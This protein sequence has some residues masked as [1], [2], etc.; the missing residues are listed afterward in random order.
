MFE[1]FLP[2]RLCLWMSLLQI[3]IVS[4]GI[5]CRTKKV[6]VGWGRMDEQSSVGCGRMTERVREGRL[7][8]QCSVGRNR[9]W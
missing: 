6:V 9:L 2:I 7:A 4:A 5:Q 1:V 3:S 8:E